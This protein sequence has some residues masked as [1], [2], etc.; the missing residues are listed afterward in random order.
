M[1]KS[2][3]KK[4]KTKNNKT[5]SSLKTNKSRR[6]LRPLKPNK[7]NK[8]S[9]EEIVGIY[10]AVNKNYGFVRTLIDYNDEDKKIY[11]KKENSLNALDGDRVLVEILPIKTGVSLEG[12]IT[13]IIEREKDF[14]IGVFEDKGNFGFV[15]PINK[16]VPFDIHIAKKFFKDAV[17]DSIVSV[18]LL[19]GSD[20]KI[21]PEGIIMEVL[22]NKNDPNIQILS[23]IKDFNI[24]EKFNDDTLK[25]AE[26]VAIEIKEID[27]KNRKDLRHLTTITIDGLDAKDLDDAISLEELNNGNVKLYVSIADVSHYVKEE[28]AIDKEA[29]KRGNSVYLI[30]RVIPMIPHILS[31]GMCSLNG[32]VDRLA[33]TCEIEYDKDTNVLNHKIYKSIINSNMRMSY[34]GVDSVLNDKELN[35]GENIEDYK[36]Y[37]EYL[38]K[39]MTLSRKLRKKREERGAVE[40]NFK[41]VKVL[42]DENLKP[43]DVV[44]VDRLEAHE[45]IEDFMLAANEA[46]AKEYAEREIPFIYRT[47]EDCDKDKVL[48]LL[49]IL[50][51]FQIGVPYKEKYEPMDIQKIV[52]KVNGKPEQFAVEKMA[53]RSMKQAKYTKD[54]I[55]H[56]ALASKYYTHFTSPIRRY[57]D[58]QIHR[59]ISE[60][61]ENKLNDS[62]KDHYDLILDNVAMHI[63]DTERRAVECEREVDALKEC[64]YMQ[65]K[66][67]NEYK[68][69]VSS[70]T[71]F[72]VFIELDNGIEGMAAFK[73]MFDDHYVF[74]EEKMV[75]LGERNKKIIN[76]GDELK[77]QVVRVN[78]DL[79]IIDFKILWE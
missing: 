4:S 18:K 46:V 24:P 21:N 20:K 65:D 31:N 32:N 34:T 37:K 40:F 63:S 5:R 57:S 23:I 27:L 42:V 72:G 79:R 26:D 6:P 39:M 35:N 58:L 78:V 3:N 33:M 49:K 8:K 66:I 73:D 70:L 29:L 17:T 19:A 44:K 1:K 16:K 53:L 38:E 2:Q 75:V 60:D 54:P 64:E 48:N 28:S 69:K 52:K 67:G 7:G 41:E 74:D 22:G 56:F 30:D 71:N 55:G 10:E 36:P 62:R 50:K 77:I 47:H 43:I 76:I 15:E 61:L 9:G 25:E 12:S 59:I 13:K 68:G 14:I 45:L 51:N 11:V